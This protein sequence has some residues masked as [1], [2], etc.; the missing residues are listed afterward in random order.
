MLV[1]FEMPGVFQ[2]TLIISFSISSIC[3]EMVNRLNGYRITKVKA[4]AKFQ[5]RLDL[6]PSMSR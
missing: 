1:K 3:S 4:F 2:A 5:A 6:P